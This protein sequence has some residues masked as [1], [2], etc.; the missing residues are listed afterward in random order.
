M[1]LNHPYR[2]RV[3]R[4][5][6]LSAVLMLWGFSETGSEPELL[7]TKRTETLNAHK[8]QYAFPGGVY[9]ESDGKESGLL[10]TALREANEEVGVELSALE[11]LG[12]LPELSTPSGF[13]IQPYVGV[14]KEFRERT[15]FAI[16]AEE[17][18]L[19]LWIPLSVLRA[20]H[21]VEQIRIGNREFDTDV[22][23]VDGHRIWGATGAM[24]RNFLERLK[25]F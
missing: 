8:G 25:D 22:Y 11:V 16:A 14:L 15:S 10:M 23:F 19:T 9:E 18:D 7:I 13:H 12:E 20:N 5:G 24:I 17:I 2:F 4:E 3:L 1:K 21:R 6:K